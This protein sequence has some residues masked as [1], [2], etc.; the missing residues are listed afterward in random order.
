MQRQ[1][2][3]LGCKMLYSAPALEMALMRRAAGRQLPSEV[4]DSFQLVA[5]RAHEQVVLLAQ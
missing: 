1:E 4:P 3:P 2:I 5:N